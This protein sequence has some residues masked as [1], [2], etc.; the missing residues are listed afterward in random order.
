VADEGLTPEWDIQYEDQKGD[1]IAI[2]VKGSVGQRFANIELTAGEWN[3]AHKLGDRYWLFLV[4]DCCG[5][6]PKIQ[7]LHNPAKLV[8]SGSAQLVPVVF[9]FT[10]VAT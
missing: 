4:A 1:V 3:A 7:R 10:S 5:D 2:E 9:R 6:H 8:A